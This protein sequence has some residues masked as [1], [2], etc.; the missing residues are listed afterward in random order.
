MDETVTAADFLPRTRSLAAARRA[1][2]V[3]HGC[4]LYLEATGTVFGEGARGAVLMLVG[5]QPGDAEDRAGRPFVG[6]AGRLLD[7]CLVAAG[8]DRATTYVTNAVKHFRWTPKGKRRL[9]ARPSAGHIQHCKPWVELELEL[10]KPRALV[11][12]G[13]VA[14]ASFFGAQFRVTAQRG[15]FL[16]SELAPLVM[17]TVHPSSLL[18]APDA[19]ARARETARFVADLSSVKAAFDATP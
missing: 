11:L 16:A 7:T 8:I 15:Q 14:A 18:R 13:A 5:E 3:C 1:A 12:M 10:V 4:D 19:A 9:H 6:P 2:A 17:V